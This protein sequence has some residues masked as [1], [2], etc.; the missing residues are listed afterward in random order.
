MSPRGPQHAFRV[1]L[2]GSVPFITA[3]EDS[4]YQIL[5]SLVDNAVK[6]SP[7]GGVIKLDVWCPNGSTVAVAV[8]DEGI[9]VPAG[10]EEA[11]FEKFRRTEETE[12][13]E[14]YGHG[15]GLY[16]ARKLAEAQGGEIALASEPGRGS[17]FTLT[18][19][20]AQELAD[21]GDNPAD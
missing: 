4:L 1:T 16:I 17:T 15:L 5:S 10:M 18:L 6:Y 11:V 9:G 7:A 3:D 14:V 12:S 2:H 21:V 13:K 19:P 8:A 20:I